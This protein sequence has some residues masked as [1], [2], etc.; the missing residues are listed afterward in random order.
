MDAATGLS[1]EAFDVHHAD[2][3]TR[4]RSTLVEAIAVQAL[5]HIPLHELDVHLE[6][7]QY[8]LIDLPLQLVSLLGGEVLIMGDVQARLLHG[9]VGTGLPDMVPE[10]VPRCSVDD[11]G[12]SVVAHQLH[13]PRPVDAALD[14]GTDRRDRTVD[15]MQNGGLH[16]DDTV[17][18]V[19]IKYAQV[20]LLA[21]TLGIEGGLVQ[22]DTSIIDPKDL[23]IEMVH[24]RVLVIEHIGSQACSAGIPP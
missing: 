9:L 3:L 4:H 15:E 8:H 12:R 18:P 20:P 19:P 21:A 24:L 11:M 23:G 14:D 1:V 5:G 6:V 17:D 22:H 16:L 13:P 10:E 2:D 7:L